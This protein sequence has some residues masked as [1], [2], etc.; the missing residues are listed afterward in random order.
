MY[1]K[2]VRECRINDEKAIIE[3]SYPTFSIYRN[4]NKSIYWLVDNNENILGSFSGD[5]YI[6]SPITYKEEL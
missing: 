2:L 3:K 4:E 5:G 6:V 1:L